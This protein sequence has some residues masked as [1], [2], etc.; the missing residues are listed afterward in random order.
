ME[1]RPMTDLLAEA[2]AAGA[3]VT[4]YINYA[5]GEDMV[6]FDQRGLVE[7]ANRIRAAERERLRADNDVSEELR[8]VAGDGCDCDQNQ[9][10]R[11]DCKSP[12]NM[13]IARLALDEAGNIMCEALRKLPRFSAE[14]L[15]EAE[16]RARQLVASIKVE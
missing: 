10:P 12:C 6:L 9:D 14:E 13:R 11:D 2:K 1:K 7:F 4:D 15:A 5:F 8:R 16:E 3:E